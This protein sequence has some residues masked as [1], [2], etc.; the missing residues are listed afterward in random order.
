M[1]T[2]TA[3][4]G[5]PEKYTKEVIEKVIAFAKAQGVGIKKALPLF[6][7]STLTASQRKKKFEPSMKYVPLLVAAARV[8]I[9]LRAVMKKV[10]A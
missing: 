5:R 6:E 2:S 4:K 8:G 10:Q 3:S 1:K 7:K 9:S